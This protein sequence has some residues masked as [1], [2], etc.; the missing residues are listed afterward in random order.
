VLSALRFLRGTPFDVFGWTAHRRRERA[1]IGAYERV[2]EELLEE[3]TPES[4][5]LA[6]EIARLPEGIRGFDLIKERSI[7]ETE[8]KQAELLQAFRLQSSS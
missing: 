8:H 2:V 4:H 5:A 3:I 7:Q 1:L 6:A